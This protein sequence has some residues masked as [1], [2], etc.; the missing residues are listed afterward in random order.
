MPISTRAVLQSTFAFLVVGLVALLSIVGMTFWLS[1]RAQTYFSVAF[2][3][4]DT[5]TAAVELRSAIQEAESSQRGYLLTGNEIYLAPYDTAKAEALKQLA[6]LEQLL[7]PYPDQA[8]SVQRLDTIV[9][10]KFDEIDQTITLKRARH[11]DAAMALVNTNKGKALTD[12]ANVFFSGIIRQ[13]DDRLTAGTQEQRRNAWLLRLVSGIGAIVIVAVAGG[14]AVVIYRYTGELRLARDQVNTLNVELEQR[15]AERTADLVTARDRAEMLLSE[16]NHRVA[17][18]L[19][20]VSS[21]VS[22]QAKSLGDDA[23]RKA[24]A[25]TQDRIFAISLVHRRLYSSN[26]IG[27]VTLDEYLKGLLDH[28][29]TSLRS[30]GQG[31]TV[32]YE[33]APVQLTTDASVNLG[34]IVTEW[35]TNAF[36]YAYPDGSGEIRVRVAA[37]GDGQIELVVEDDGVGRAE[38]APAKGTGLGSRIVTAMAASLSGTIDYRSR[39]PGTE[40]RLVF[41]SQQKHAKAAE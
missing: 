5:Q 20:L 3:A 11:D 12:E 26:A 13:A 27:V 32:S 36:K 29:Q 25:E 16:V 23:A 14:A 37:L 7:A 39:G 18:S 22:L 38:G 30:E 2:E 15:V 41:N 34:V 33:L 8:N 28:L 24:L 35:V 10:E 6:A 31:A 4:R 19:A 1:E 17:N 9:A 40:A 21:L